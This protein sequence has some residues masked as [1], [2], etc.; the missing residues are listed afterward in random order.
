M[1]FCYL[2][3][4]AFGRFQQFQQK[5]KNNQLTCQNKFGSE[6]IGN[7]QRLSV[8]CQVKRAET[9]ITHASNVSFT[10]YTV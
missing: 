1:A 7:S 4:R 3:G 5:R 9:D 8:S 10:M 6:S 2:E